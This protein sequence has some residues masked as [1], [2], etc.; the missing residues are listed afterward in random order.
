MLASFGLFFVAAGILTSRFENRGS[1]A[2]PR[3]V[4]A[5]IAF[6]AVIAISDALRE[7]PRQ[8]YGRF[9]VQTRG[10]VRGRYLVFIILGALALYVL[11][12]PI[13]GFSIASFVFVFAVQ[14]IL[15]PRRTKSVVIAF[16]IALIFS[17]GINWL[18]A[19]VFTVFLPRGVF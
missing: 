2:F 3:I 5:T 7:V 10:W 11:A 13:I 4:L 8:T 15:M 1:G 17:V 14:V 12:I 18:F 19:E 6:L 9:A 16:V